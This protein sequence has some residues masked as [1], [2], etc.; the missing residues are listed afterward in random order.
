M[1]LENKKLHQNRQFPDSILAN[2]AYKSLFS[3]RRMSNN[4][5]ILEYIS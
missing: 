3:P 1:A 2:D 5:K 4:L